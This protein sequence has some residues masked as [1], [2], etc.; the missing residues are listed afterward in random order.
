[1]KSLS[2][3]LLFAALTFAQGTLAD[4]QRGQGLQA[5]ARGRVVPDSFTHGTSAQRT[6]WFK[7]GFETGD[8]AGAAKLFDLAYDR[9]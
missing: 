4:Y 5:K 6:R 7:Q 8:I 9:L 1:M 2:V 3:A